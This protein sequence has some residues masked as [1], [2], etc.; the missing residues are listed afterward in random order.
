MYKGALSPP[1]SAEEVYI[2][3]I[4]KRGADRLVQLI[5]PHHTDDNPLHLDMI[6]ID[7]Q[8]LH[9][10]IGRLQAHAPVL[11]I[12]LLQR[13]IRAAEECDNHFPV[14]GG[15]AVLDDDEFA[16]ADVLVNHRIALDA[17]HI[18]VAL[19]RQ[20]F[21]NGDGFAA[22]HRFN[23]RA[24]GDEAKKR[25]LERATSCTRRHELD[26]SA[27]VPGAAN[28]TFLLQV[29]QMLVDRRERRQVEATSDFLQAW[30]IAVVLNELVQVVEDFTLPFR[31]R[32]HFF[33]PI[34]LRWA[35]YNA[36]RRRKSTKFRR[37]L[38]AEKGQ[39][40]ALRLVEATIYTRNR[41]PA[42]S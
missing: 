6:R 7:H 42:R 28:K 11:P 33:P 4:R 1:Q 8:R 13:D 20:R 18:G 41:Q 16:I 24:G 32:E 30:R 12:E 3:G 38:S 31:E 19:A 21:R 15:F 25:E 27:P 35:D 5:L 14:V 22:G 39:T 10:R 36:N 2:S 17:Q 23:R 40:R 37:R 29:G 34:R 9:C 26:R